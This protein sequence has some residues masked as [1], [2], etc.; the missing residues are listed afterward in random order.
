M[1]DN[2]VTQPRNSSVMLSRLSR[3]GRGGDV[4]SGTKDDRARVDFAGLSC[5]GPHFRDRPWQH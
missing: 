5:G 4:L 2:G 3:V 1:S